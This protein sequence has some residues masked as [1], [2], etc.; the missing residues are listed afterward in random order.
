MKF[1]GVEALAGLYIFAFS[2]GASAQQDRDFRA[3]SVPEDKSSA[4]RSCADAGNDGDDALRQLFPFLG[5]WRSISTYKQKNGPDLVGYGTERI[6]RTMSGRA[7][8]FQSDLEDPFSPGAPNF[9]SS[10]VWMVRPSTGALVGAAVNSLGNRKFLDGAIDNGD[11]VV[12]VQGE[13]FAGAD[14]IERYRYHLAADDRI[15]VSLQV[16]AD[17]GRSWK[18]GG[19]EAIY[20]RARLATEFKCQ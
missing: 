11:L 2:Q 14:Q 4:S 5:E 9:V 17:E 7:I 15:E 13:M 10:A 3:A 16:S 6:L 18:T 1:F 19:Y 20:E 12:T 8:E